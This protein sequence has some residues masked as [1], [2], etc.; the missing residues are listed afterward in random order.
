VFRITLVN[1]SVGN[2]D[3]LLQVVITGTGVAAY[4]VRVQLYSL[5][6]LL[7][8]W[9]ECSCFINLC[10]LHSAHANLTINMNCDFSHYSA[11]TD[12][13]DESGGFDEEEDFFDDTRPSVRL[14]VQH[15]RFCSVNAPSDYSISIDSITPTGDGEVSG[16]VGANTLAYVN[17][18]CIRFPQV[19]SR[20]L[21][22][23]LLALSLLPNNHSL[24]VPF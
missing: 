11:A 7:L 24:L 13:D 10:S 5:F 3:D 22:S 20:S 4:V 8:G 9:C 16:Q 19:Q 18:T 17:H 23:P 21:L 6:M 14:S 1:L 2:I 15:S 12:F